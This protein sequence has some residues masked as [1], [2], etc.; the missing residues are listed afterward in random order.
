[1]LTFVANAQDDRKAI[2][3]NFD[4]VVYNSDS[5]ISSVYKIKKGLREGYAIEF[6]KKIPIA[7]GEYKKGKKEGLW[8]FDYGGGTTY[9]KGESGIISLPENRQSSMDYFQELYRK[10]IH[11]KKT[12]KDRPD[13][14]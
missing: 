3:A 1:M 9:K 14:F 12:L 5:S 4:S 13:G 2:I 10:L 11:K 8:F 6:E 7:I